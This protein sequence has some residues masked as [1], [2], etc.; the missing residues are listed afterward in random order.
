MAS[1]AARKKQQQSASKK[2][3][4]SPRDRVI[5]REISRTPP[6]WQWRTF[7]VFFALVSGLLLASFVN[8]TPDNTIAAIVQLAAIGGF[9]Y[10]LAHLFV[11]N[12]I[13]AGR[14]KR[15]A[16][17]IGRGDVPAE[18]WEDETIYP[19]EAPAR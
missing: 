19:D 5:E 10:G 2:Q 13:V 17:A 16:E 7:P 3:G 9:G 8:G 6:R 14:A 4:P 15:R 1:K 11:T 18:D 12:V